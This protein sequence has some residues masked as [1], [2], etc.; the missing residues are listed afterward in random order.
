MAEADEP[1]GAPETTSEPD[2]GAL[3][4]QPPTNDEADTPTGEPANSSV[5]P[6]VEPAAPQKTSWMTPDSRKRRLLLAAGIYLL[7][8]IVFA[9]F[10]G[11]DRMGTHTAFNHYAHLADAWLHGKHDI[12]R[13]GPSYAGG[14]DFADFQGKTYISFPPLPAV[15]MLPLVWLSGSPENFRDGQFIVWLAG[16]GP[17]VLFLVLEKLRRTKRSER[18]E[19]E[20]IALTLA[21]AFG[22]VYFF[23]AVQGTVWFA[24]HVVGVGALAC[25]LLFSMDAERPFLAGLALSCAWTSRVLMLTVGVFFVLEAIR[26]SCKDH[27]NIEG[28]LF[29]RT[30]TILRRVDRVHLAKLLALFAAPLL[31]SFALASAYNQARFGDP[32]PFAFGHEY[33]PW[34]RGSRLSAWGLFSYHYLPKNLGCVLTSM[35]YMAPKGGDLRGAPFQVNAHGLALWFTTP[36]YLFLLWPKKRGGLH[37][38]LWIAALG[39]ILGNLL[40]QNTGWAQFGY[41]FSN[42][43]AL[44]FFVL[45]AIGARPIRKLFYVMAFWG[46]MWNAFGAASFDRADYGSYYFSARDI[47]YQPD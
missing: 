35:P 13:G 45:I 12:T 1:K 31:V 47:L 11:K 2:D 20:N 37:L 14:N 15:L 7:A 40:Y 6:P 23:T 5:A 33:L 34:V 36:V 4:A 43:Y 24:A 18:S 3:N 42:D 22:S 32:R 39:P 38:M 9:V 19:W 26:V 44:I 46:L 8:V 17:A 28:G 29:A 21:F 10:A 25:F 30:E 27:Q 16:V 41:R